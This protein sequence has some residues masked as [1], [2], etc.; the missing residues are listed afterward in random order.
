[1]G[2]EFPQNRKESPMRDDSIITEKVKTEIERFSQLL[3]QEFTKPKKKF[4]SQMLFGIQASRD[5]KLSNISRSLDE[6]IKLIKTENRLSRN[7]QKEDLTKDLN[8]IIVRQGSKKILPDTILALD[9]SDIAKPFAKKMDGLAH[10]WNG[11]EGKPDQGYWILAVTA[12][13][14]DDEAIVP[15]YSELYS[16][17]AS[18]LPTENQI[19]G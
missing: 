1:M 18:S 6:D 2:K 15:L 10:V 16:Y 19:K 5:V 17:E 4:I 3:T 13:N 14:V 12:A 9:L 7:A 11:S 8:E